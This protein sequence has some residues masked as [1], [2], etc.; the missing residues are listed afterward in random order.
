[1]VAAHSAAPVTTGDITLGMWDMTQNYAE[2]W[3]SG[4]TCG[5]ACSR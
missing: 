1:M 3:Q 4:G 2:C 5:N